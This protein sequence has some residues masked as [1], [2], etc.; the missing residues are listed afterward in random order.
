[1]YRYKLNRMKSDMLRFNVSP[2]FSQLIGRQ[3]ISNPTVAV[4]E[5]V[6]NSY[7]ADA[8]DINVIFEDIKSQNGRIIIDD[9]GD[10]MTFD[11]L[12]SKWMVIGTD[13][14]LHTTYTS[15]SG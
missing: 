1:M 6:K 11:D 15:K 7:D 4:L 5:I 2:R 3:L 9:D 14:K 8:N 12:K 13:N 10:G